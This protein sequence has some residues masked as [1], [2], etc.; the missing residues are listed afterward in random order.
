[1]KNSSFPVFFSWRFFPT[2]LCSP[3]SFSTPPSQRR[4]EKSAQ[5]RSGLLRQLR[6]IYKKLQELVLVPRGGKAKG[7]NRKE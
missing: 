1:M 2:P 4:L 6:W 7:K 5:F 3:Q